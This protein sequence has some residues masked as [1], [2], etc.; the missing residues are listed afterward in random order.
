[1]LDIFLN[2]CSIYEAG[3]EVEFDVDSSDTLNKQIRNAQIAQ[4][5]FILVVGPAEARNGTV[6]V[7]TRDNAVSSCI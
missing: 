2:I 1:M 3:F 5:N 4:F 7:R 6:N